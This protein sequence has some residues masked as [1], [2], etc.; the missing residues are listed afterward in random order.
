MRRRD[1][2]RWLVPTALAQG[3]Y[4]LL[5]GLAPLVSRRGFEWVTG[6]KHDWWLV[7]MVGL[8]AT[9]VGATLI[10]STYDRLPRSSALLAIGSALAF[11][12]VDVVYVA[13]G[14]IRPVYLADAA[15]Q[16][17]FI[18]AWTVGLRRR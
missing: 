16:A 6:P 3:G 7:I 8:L 14:V 12:A 9:V 10:A 5:T 1:G 11:L 13:R 15:V 18:G 4:D 17:A 2:A